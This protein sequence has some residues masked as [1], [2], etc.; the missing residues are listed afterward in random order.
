MEKCQANTEA[1]VLCLFGE[2]T[3]TIPAFITP[4][5]SLDHLLHGGRNFSDFSFF[6]PQPGDLHK[7]SLNDTELTGVEI[8][9]GEIGNYRE[10][11]EG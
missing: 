1:E 8:D 4:A 5:H 9:E 2:E 11:E 3:K 6:N 7:C 10:E